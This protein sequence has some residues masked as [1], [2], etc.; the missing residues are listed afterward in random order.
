M[1]K[2]DD[3]QA[4][5]A[6]NLYSQL[7]SVLAVNL[8]SLSIGLAAGYS[9]VLLP[10]I[11]KENSLGIIANILAP[12][13]INTTSALYKPFT[14]DKTEEMWIDWM[15]IVGAAFGG[16]L[17]A[18]LGHLLGSRR[19][20][21]LLSL[22][23]LTG[24]VL[25]ASS[26]SLSLLLAGRLLTGI[27][28]GGY[29][30][31]IQI[32]VAE[33]SQARHR[34]WLAGL[35]MPV[36]ATGVLAMQVTGSLLSWS[37]AAAA[38]MIVPLLLAVCVSRLWDSPYWYLGKKNQ[39]KEALAALQHFRSGDPNI[40]VEML[41]IQENGSKS[42]TLISSLRKL[43][44]D[45]RYYTPLFILNAIFL[46]MAFSGKFTID[47]YTSTLFE[48]ASGN[49][50]AYFS[51]VVTSLINLIGSCAYIPLVRKLP[52]KLLF[53]ASALVMGLSLT[54][55]GVSMYCHTLPSVAAVWIT[56]STWIPL[57]AA[58]LYF[59]AAPVGFYSIPYIYTAEFFPTEVRSLL[60]GLTVAFANISVLLMLM[61]SPTLVS[62][63]GHP[64]QVFFC[65]GVCLVAPCLILA[66]VPETKD[67]TVGE[68]VTA[69]F[70]DWRK[71]KRSSPWGS[72]AGSPGTER[73]GRGELFTL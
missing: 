19:M 52:R 7:V 5:S 55:L 48:H 2:A 16:L 56:Q 10:S 46:L 68:G 32:Y 67:R 38:A 28:A 21:I 57:L 35:T 17:S 44:T 70:R 20:L 34:G 43:V 66:C 62:I 36:M 51:S 53:S 47:P 54:M 40:L 72:P 73:R 65:A 64:G 3:G 9:S 15:L 29:F 18:F 31:N 58:T 42:C 50:T 1:K 37:H 59:L 12:H 26:P 8:G 23:D 61:I 13:H 6:I 63:L 22:P 49:K 25:I 24:W 11:R 69:Q 45:K 14:V 33:I 27:A 4:Y 60:S 30:S 71:E 39:E 41:E